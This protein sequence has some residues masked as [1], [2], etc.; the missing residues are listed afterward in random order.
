MRQI[1]TGILYILL[2]VVCTSACKQEKQKAKL[3]SHPKKPEEIKTVA[4]KTV[5]PTNSTEIDH[6]LYEG[7]NLA[8]KDDIIALD[9][10]H[11][12]TPFYM[13]ILDRK[14][15]VICSGK[16]NGHYYSFDENQKYGLV[17]DSLEVMLPT[18]YDKIYNPDLVIKNCLEIELNDK[19]GLVNYLSGEV[20]SPQFDYIIPG[21]SW[22]KDIAYGWKNDQMYRIENTLTSKPEKSNFDPLPILKIMSFDIED[23]DY[24]MMYHSYW[25]YDEHDENEGKGIVFVPSYL[26]YLTGRTNPYDHIILPE[27]KGFV[28]FGLVEANINTSAKRSLSDKITA[29]FLSFY[30][31][32]AGARGYHVKTQQMVIHD[33]A[34]NTLKT[35]SLTKETEYDYFCSESGYRLINDSILEIKATSNERYDFETKFTY[36]KITKDGEIKEL[37]SH[38]YYDF[39]KYIYMDENNFKGCFAKYNYNADNSNDGNMWVTDHLSI[40]D[41]DIMR[42]EIFAEYGYTFKTEKWRKYFSNESWYTPRFE[43]VDDQLTE[44]DKANIKLILEV[45]ER[46]KGNEEVYIN[47]RLASYVAAG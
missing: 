12:S 47:K 36:H 41:L 18:K 30:E 32:G 15:Y 14:F 7:L 13:D 22:P 4:N 19:I 20:L 35:L 45:K 10:K 11:G 27:Q 26:S 5:V 9:K 16:P 46:M 31:S 21:S 6:E 8:I 37:N 38:R 29:F 39:T 23:L 33:R 25:T 1:L 44:I 2:L 34:T 43:N 42:N 3:P 28:E 40:K 24:E 17:N